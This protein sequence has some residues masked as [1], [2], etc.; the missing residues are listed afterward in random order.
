[1][2][3]T[4][5]TRLGPYEIQAQIGEGGMGEVYRASDSNLKRA[6]A[7]K[8]LPESVANDS[9]RLARFRREAEVL[10]ALNHPHIAQ[11][12]GLERSGGTTALVMELVEGHTLDEIIRAGGGQPGSNVDVTSWVLPIARQIAEALEAA[13]EQGIVHRDLKPAN[14]KVRADGTV[15]VLDFGLAKTAPVTPHAAPSLA[16]MTSPA[17]TTIGVIL[18]TAAYMAPEQAKAQAVDRRA[19]VWA[20]GAVLYEM[21]TGHRAF[22]GEDVSEVLASVLAREPDWTRLPNAPALNACVRR[23]LQRDPK[24]RFGDM[25]SVRLA[26]DGAFDTNR[27]STATDGRPAVT[28]P[29]MAAWIVAG[30][31]TLL[32]AILGVAYFTRTDPV[33]AVM[34]TMIPPPDGTA[35]DFDVTV[36]PAVLSPNGQRVTFTARGAGGRIQLWVRA[37]DSTD[38]RALEGTDSAAFPFWSPDSQSIGYYNQVRGR[39]ERIS[40]AGGAPVAIVSAG[41]VRGASWGADGTIVYDA[42]GAGARVLATSASGAMPRTVVGNGEPRSPWMLPDGRHLLYFSRLA[43]EVRVVAV[44]GSDDQR[45]TNATSNAIYAAGQLLFL[46]EGTLLAQP[47]DLS[48]R[49]VSGTPVPVARNVQMLLG[50][51]RGVFSASDNGLLLY[52]DGGT[53]A[54]MSLAWFDRDGKRLMSFGEMGSARG[55][56]LSPGGDAATV[57]LLDADSRVDLWRVNTANGTRRRL[58]F[59]DEGTEISSFVAWSPDGR[60]IAYGARRDKALTIT[61]LPAEGGQEQVVFTLPAGQAGFGVAR[62]TAWTRDSSELLY[63]GFLAGGGIWRLPLTSKGGGAPLTATP[64]V[65]ETSAGQNV[66]LSP[67]G[68]WVVFQATLGT[69]TVPAIFIDAFPGGG[70]RQQVTD[71]GT[72]PVWSAEG[73]LYFA[74]DNTLTVV[75]VIES[76]GAIAFGSPRPVMSV[77]TGRGYSYDVAKDGRILALVTNEQRATRPLTLVQNWTAAR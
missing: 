30:A 8:V 38:A 58:T 15:K 51:P 41:F 75:D 74:I 14:I 4:P 24:Q 64:F 44:D 68:R 73:K 36:G 6:V 5:G 20:F 23:C 18:G 45:V 40:V 33:R 49:T 3:L 19:D 76:N 29:A 71:H 53:N 70:R 22:P 65:S 25:Q 72:L 77:V 27:P 35:F 11:I 46:R 39:L 28:R 26:L 66:R 42:S 31:A 9:E 34:R 52:Q 57:G 63:S 7:I 16:T 48:R 12:Y 13:H 56:S 37:L 32:A 10:A 21:L 59:A 17:M 61:R 67:N 1:L 47:F 43:R 69:S 55:V 2:A 62:V 54:A 50:E 60:S